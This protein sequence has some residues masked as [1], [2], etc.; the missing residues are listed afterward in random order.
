MRTATLYAS[1]YL[2]TISDKSGDQIQWMD[3]F[4]AKMTHCPRPKLDPRIS[5]LTAITFEVLMT[6]ETYDSADTR[7]SVTTSTWHRIPDTTIPHARGSAHRGTQSRTRFTHVQSE[8]QS[9]ISMTSWICGKYNVLR[10]C[11]TRQYSMVYGRFRSCD[12][13][14]WV[15]TAHAILSFKYFCYYIW[16]RLFTAVVTVH[17]WTYSYQDHHS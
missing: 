15:L 17:D 6:L 16:C 5:T 7:S 3:N 9:T 13:A 8:L 1:L 14:F 4:S 12:F 10:N 2:P 11:K